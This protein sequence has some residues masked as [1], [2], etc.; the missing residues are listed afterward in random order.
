M[1]HHAPNPAAPPHLSLKAF[2]AP[3]ESREE[4]NGGGERPPSEGTLASGN[5]LQFGRTSAAESHESDSVQWE[6]SASYPVPV[7][8]THL[9]E[10]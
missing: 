6:S 2:S 7:S 8:Y 4:R 5:E 1:H 3:F 9:V 10:T